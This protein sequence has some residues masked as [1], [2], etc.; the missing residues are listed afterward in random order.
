MPPSGEERKDLGKSLGIRQTQKL[1]QV[2]TLA[3]LFF[4]S[5]FTEVNQVLTSI[6][7]L[8]KMLKKWRKDGQ[9]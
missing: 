1:M 4:L 6:V 3:T 8:Q 9:I 5:I 7:S 2:N